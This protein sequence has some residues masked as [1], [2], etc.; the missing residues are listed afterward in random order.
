MRCLTLALL[1]AA[2]AVR[3][4]APECMEW[5]KRG[6]CPKNSVYM[7]KECPK[8]CLAYPNGEGLTTG[9]LGEPE[10]CAGWASQGECTRNPKFMMVECPE[11]C[12]EQR[13]KVH[14]GNL[15][16]RSDCLDVATGSQ[17]AANERLQ[18]E[19]AGT[20][21]SHTLCD[22]EA[23]PAECKRVLRCRELKD[24]WPDCTSRVEKSGCEDPSTASTLLK[25]C[26]LSC[27]R[28]DREG[29]MR[30]FRLK[31]TVRTRKYGLVDEE[32]RRSA[33]PAGVPTLSLPCWKETVFDPPPPATCNSTRAAKLNHWRRLGHPRCTALRETTP[34]A[35]PRR[36]L[37]LPADMLPG[38]APGGDSVGTRVRVMPL[39]KSPKVRLVENFVS[40]EEA[41]HVVRVGLPR[42]HR[43]LAGGRTES[44]RTST[45]AMLPADDPV[46]RRITE[47]AA[48]VTGY[49]YENIEPLQ[50]VKYVDGQRYEPHFDYGEACDFEE[51]MHSGHRHVT[52]LV[53]LNS[54]PEESGGFTVFPKL[55]IRLSP[56]AQSAITF[57]D[58]LPN[59]EEDPRTL[60]G[61]QPPSNNHT[62]IAINIWIR[63]QARGVGTR[64]GGGSLLQ[65]LAAGLS[66]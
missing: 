24:D 57:N 51:N 36:V 21:A 39:L 46:V 26:Y 33:R 10:Q 15:D 31:Y 32:A 2:A 58:C 5:A 41:E 64:T 16:E 30:R 25:H 40:A 11:N 1:V 35:P 20:C 17:C 4:E 53:Y 54:V 50:L 47:R 14:E 22:G 49:P 56:V 60:H 43:S 37:R 38:A 3:A 65:K 6:E 27:A 61:G 55:G 62:K 34:R 13:A 8:A 45:T 19:C 66:L 48:L 44:I 18:R 9:P 63:A 42:M 7:N 12:R 59:G 28:H 23:D 29:L 52:M